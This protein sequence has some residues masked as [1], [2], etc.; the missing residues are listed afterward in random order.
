MSLPLFPHLDQSA[1]AGFRLHRFEVLNWGT[2]HEKIWT[3]DFQGKTA[4]LTGANGSGKSTLV[5]GLLTLLV[6]SKKRNYNQASSSLGKRER[7]EK[8]YVQGAYGGTRLD[9]DYG[10]QS[11]FLREKGSI[12]I[13][14]AYFHNQIS[15]KELSLA[16]VLWLNQ[17]QIQKFFVVAEH[18]LTIAQDFPS[19]TIPELKQHLKNKGAEIFTEFSKYSQ[20]FLKIFGLQSF[21]ALDLFNQTVSL[22]EIKGFNDFV[23]QQMLQKESVQTLIDD[24]DKAYNDLTSTHNIITKAKEQLQLLKPL[25]E[26]SNNL[27]QILVQIKHFDGL[28]QVAPAYFARIKLNLIQ[29]K[30]DQ[31]EQALAQSECLRKQ[32]AIEL[33]SLKEKR[34]SLNLAISKNSANQRL[35]ELETEIKLLSQEISKQEQK[36]KDYNR[37]ASYLQFPESSDLG[38]FEQVRTV[39]IPQ[40]RQEIS[41]QIEQLTLQRDNQIKILNDRQKSRQ[42]LNDELTSLRQR[43][44]QIPSESLRLRNQ[45]IQSLNLK[46]ID[47][48]FIGELLQVHPEEKRWEAAIERLLHSFGL[49]V[50][51][52]ERYF[53]H[54][55]RYVND[56]HLKGRFVYHKVTNQIEQKINFYPNSVPSKLEIKSDNQLFYSWLVQRLNSKFSYVCCES[57]EDLEREKQAITIKGLIKHLAN[58]YE[59]DDRITFG[60]RRN[61][62]L[63]WS[64]QEKIKLL[65][66]ELAELEA[67]LSQIN[68]QISRLEKE[69]KQ[70]ETQKSWLEFLD[71]F[72]DFTEIDWQ[73]NQSKMQQL[74]QEREELIASSNQLQQLQNELEQ[75]ENQQKVLAAEI[76]NLS[77]TIG[78]LSNQ[79]TSYE[80]QENQACDL[81][82][83]SSESA[84]NQFQFSQSNRLKR[85]QLTLESISQDELKIIGLLQDEREQLKKQQISC[86]NSIIGQ[87]ANFRNKFPEDVSEIS[88]SLEDLPVYLKLIQK[89]END[90]LPRHEERFKKMMNDTII[91]SIVH[92]KQSLEEQEL[93]IKGSIDELNQALQKI[94]YSDSTYIKLQY[95]KSRDREINDFRFQ[96]LL[97]CIGYAVKQSPEANEQRFYNISQLINKL[98]EQERWREKVTDVRNWLDF[99]VS[100]YGRENDEEQDYY[101]ESSGKSGGQKAKL[102]YTVLAAAIAHQFGLNQ[103]H[104]DYKSLRFVVIDEAFSKLDDSNARYAMELFKTLNLQLLVVTPKDKIHV[105]ENYVHSIHLISNN[106]E[107]DYSS[108]QSVS[109]DQFK[110]FQQSQ[111]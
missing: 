51:V 38:T 85:Y 96:D 23:R 75:V 104:S 30:L 58:R 71:H 60:D 106:K 54:V 39:L 79:K 24:L 29:Q 107:G 17:N 97:N 64:N 90:D 98:K 9:D 3:L 18:P 59:K 102:A 4:L 93:R 80:S 46:E 19:C 16:Q 110:S 35:K 45:I 63:G 78:S 62:I 20:A 105:T 61:Y 72:Q 86:Q 91:Y 11:K 26:Q 8:S 53:H 42:E 81:V 73:S 99:S 31:I 47:L 83:Q 21:K 37:Y 68:Q 12:S 82:N 14:V 57:Q 41:Q 5:D 13:L 34:D 6:P 36:A 40:K 15:Q 67:K 89:I 50:L 108:L 84:L 43:K 7:D 2:F 100:E 92:F 101:S 25:E 22:K 10:S 87:I 94:N 65:E 32:H 55:S 88:G 44:S 111:E 56:H 48:P 77:Q 27:A 69:R 70:R 66:A 76:N 74:R 109:I 103:E 1:N 95:E 52:P 28:I 49:D 33:D